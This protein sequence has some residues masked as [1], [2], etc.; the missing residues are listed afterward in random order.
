MTKRGKIM[1]RLLSRLSTKATQRRRFR[2]HQYAIRAPNRSQPIVELVCGISKRKSKNAEQRL[3]PKM[4]AT[5]AEN[6]PYDRSETQIGD[7][8]LG[9]VNGSRMSGNRTTETVLGGWACRIRTAK[10]TLKIA[11]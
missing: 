4:P 1:D 11:L 3:A 6:S 7:L 9:N 5:Q 2:A 8:R 10:A